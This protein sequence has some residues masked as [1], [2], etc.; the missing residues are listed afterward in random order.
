MRD[1]RIEAYK[2]LVADDNPA[3]L[4]LVEAA[5]ADQGYQLAF[6]ADGQEALEVFKRQE[7]HLVIFNLRMPKV[8]GLE[9]L[10]EV[11]RISPQTEAI[12]IT[13]SAD[14]DSA[15]EAL[16]L[17]AFDYI[18]K[19][20]RL[21]Q[22]QISVGKALERYQLLVTRG[23]LLEELT[24]QTAVR[25]KEV[26]ALTA[27]AAIANRF[28]N[29]DSLLTD[30]LD[31]VL[32]VLAVEGGIV[33][34]LDEAT[35]ELHVVAHRGRSE[36]FLRERARVKLEDS[37]LVL[38]REQEEAVVIADLWEM[39]QP[40]FRL[41]KA[42]GYRAYAGIPLVARD[43]VIGILAVLSRIPGRFK[44]EEVKFL[45]SIGHQIGLGVENTRLFKEV[46]ARVD[47]FRESEARYRSLAEHA[48]DIIFSLDTQGRFVFLNQRVEEML[49]YKPET[50]LGRH[51]SQLFASED[52]ERAQAIPHEMNEPAH[53]PTVLA[54]IS[55]DGTGKVWVEISMVPLY[56]AHGQPAGLQ[57]IARD[58]TK[59][60]EM[61]EQLLRSEKLAAVGQLAAGVAHELGNALAII[62]GSVQYLLKTCEEDR[63]YHEFLEVIHRNVA[64]AD[65]TIRSLLSFAR[66]RDPAL[67]PVNIAHVLETTWLLL[68]GQL[69]KQNVNVFY[70]FSPEV[71]LV[72]ADQEQLEQVF[73]NLLLN[74]IQAMPE[75]GSITLSTAFD[76]EGNQVKI[77]VADTGQG[78]P[79]ARLS[80][81]FDP[82]FTTKPGGTGLGLSVSDR[83]IRAHGGSISVSSQE[84]EGTVFTVSLPA[85]A[86]R[87]SPWLKS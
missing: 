32:E 49:G 24:K 6:A 52:Q 78:I 23:K 51:F 70:R 39:P 5:L 27:L 12:V 18:P 68:E 86:R 75:G 85:V 44:P 82:F 84:G 66:P 71:H 9:V 40:F 60:K 76:P 64:R 17:G 80:R 45:A 2:I 77:E 67:S 25:T 62:G 34:L 87:G 73:V 46:E 31:K 74:A 63:P 38:L 58:I 8:G 29:L 35:G 37:A 14:R 3:M 36:T 22:F 56:D 72:L 54:L 79:P 19:P 28:V 41:A 55:Q 1:E 50:L 13:G 26:N 16:R 10:R 47:A 4:E 11:K 20:F 43:R 83:L 81:I 48:P 59:R 69:A 42:D 33:R 21:E 65:R 53:L 15:V 30:A 61:E 7:P 57:G